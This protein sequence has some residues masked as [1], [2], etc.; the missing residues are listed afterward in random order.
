[1]ATKARLHWFW[2]GVIA[3]LFGAAAVLLGAI[4]NAIFLTI[5]L[6][7][8]SQFEQ[9]SF[10]PFVIAAGVFI[11]SALPSVATY[12]LLSDL[13]G[14]P[15]YNVRHRR[16]RLVAITV[17]LAAIC[18]VAI[19]A[20]AGQFETPNPRNMLLVFSVLT[21]LASLTIHRLLLHFLGREVPDGEP[22]CRKCG[23]ILRGLSEPRCPEC[24]EAI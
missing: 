20:L 3:V 10:G 7:T 21:S 2:R 22:H 16:G 6:V 18:N 11:L 9:H 5:G 17:L 8:A 23:Y 19:F 14:P 13:L 15:P 24:G 1:M 4:A 12:V